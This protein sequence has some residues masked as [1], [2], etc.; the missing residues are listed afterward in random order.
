MTSMQRRYLTLV[1]GLLLSLPFAD[2]AHAGPVEQLV[3]LVMHPTDPKVM[4]VRYMN[5]GD[6]IFLTHDGGKSWSLLCDAAL[7]DPVQTKSGPLAIAG[8][9][10]TLMG[11]FSGMWHDDGRGCGWSNEPKYDH[12]WIADFALD[13]LDPNILY[14]VTS[15]AGTGKVNGVVRRD[16]SGAWSDLGVKA[17]LLITRLHV[18]AHGKGRRFYMGAVKGQIA[19]ADG[20][21]PTPNY[22]FRVSDDD[23][24]TWQE[25]VFGTTDGEVR[26]LGIDPTNTD[27]LVMAIHKPEDGPGPPGPKPDT[28]MVSSDQG[29]TFT[30][31]MK[32]T[33]IGGVAF[34]P[35]GR[36]WIGDTGANSDP[37]APRGV[38]FAQS[39]DKPATKLP[40]TDYPVQC[41]G[42]QKATDTLYACQH[43]WFGAVDQADGSFKSELDMTQVSTFASCNGVDMAATC[44]MQLCGAYCGYGHF[45]QAPVCGAYKLPTCG[46]AAAEGLTSTTTGGS[47]GGASTG[48]AGGM[49][50]R[51]GGVTDAAVTVHT[52]AGHASGTGGTGGAGGGGAKP[53]GGCG[54]AAVG[55]RRGETWFAILAALGV[56]ALVRRRKRR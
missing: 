35:D 37:M 51:D 33:D 45:A 8:D 2:V 17:D 3:Q 15:T 48:G 40:M 56:T 24:A 14:S 38:W 1:F 19:P 11:V 20:G 47:G 55:A 10:T 53:K 34:A 46:P 7:F 9:G 50:A 4:A 23:G 49:G 54:V 30:E 22:V 28:V 25:H 6:G 21:T 42:Y 32:V 43:W 52:D 44:Q 29:A 31:Y 16:A 12:E 36:V 5:G 18:V 26:L 41:L 39:L 27:R 13:P